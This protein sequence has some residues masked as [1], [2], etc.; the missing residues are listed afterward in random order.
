MQFGAV[1]LIRPGP[2]APWRHHWQAIQTPQIVLAVREKIG[3]R[4]SS[5]LLS[6]R[7]PAM[8]ET[9]TEATYTA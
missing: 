8:S 3:A 9:G 5:T 1:D 7:L 4:S 6:I 2:A